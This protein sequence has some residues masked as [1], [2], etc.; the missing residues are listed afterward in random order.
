MLKYKIPWKSVQWEPNCPMRTDR[1]DMTKLRVSFR[2]FANAPNKNILAI[3]KQ[4]FHWTP[5]QCV[6]CCDSFFLRAYVSEVLSFPIYKI[7][8]ATTP[9]SMYHRQ[10]PQISGL[11]SAKLRIWSGSS[12]GDGLTNPKFRHVKFSCP[13]QLAGESW[14]TK[15]YLSQYFISKLYYII[16]L[17]CT[18][19]FIIFIS[20]YTLFKEQE[21]TSQSHRWRTFNSM[22]C[23]KKDVICLILGKEWILLLSDLKISRLW[24]QSRVSQNVQQKPVLKNS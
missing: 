8:Y 1:Q 13:R 17:S 3:T 12:F 9:N 11:C 23:T 21:S 18:I 14:E 10:T 2:N 4:K 5:I 15:N 22:A 16:L 24:A 6:F 7:M 20:H 19:I